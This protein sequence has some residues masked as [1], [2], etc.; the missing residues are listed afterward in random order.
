MTDA[1]ITRRYLAAETEEER[2]EVVKDLEDADFKRLYIAD[3]EREKEELEAWLRKETEWALSEV[4]REGSWWAYEARGIRVKVHDNGDFCAQANN[5]ELAVSRC[6]DERMGRLV[7]GLAGKMVAALKVPR[8]D[9]VH[10]FW[11]LQER[12]ARVRR[13]LREDRDRCGEA[14]KFKLEISGL[15]RK[16]AV[17]LGWRAEDRGCS[18]RMREE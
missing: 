2:D 8:D 3:L 16:Q 9:A 11:G 18:V 12:V 13:Y 4:E 6:Y 1:E 5:R 10:A 15:T 17:E 7:E 14:P